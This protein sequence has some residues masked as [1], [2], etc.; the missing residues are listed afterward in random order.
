[1]SA[2]TSLIGFYAYAYPEAKMKERIDNA[3]AS[4]KEEGVEVNFI[5]YV[6]DRDEESIKKAKEKLEKTAY[7]STSITLVISA[8]VE[9]PPVIRVISDHFHMPMLMWSIAGYRIDA[10]LVSP[11]DAAG[12]T[13]LNFALKTFGIKH[14]SL[15]DIV[16][17]KSR[18]D[19]AAGF[20]KFADSLKNLRNTRIASF[21]YADMDL[22]PL[23]YDGTLIKKYTGIHVDNLDLIE[24]KI[25]MD[26]VTKDQ[27]SA[28]EKDLNNKVN[29]VHEPTKRDMEILARSYIAINKII[30]E[31]NYKAISLKCQFGMSKL[32]N[33]SPCM[34]ESLIGDKV[35]TICECDVP[36]L[37]AQVVVKE[38]TETKSVFQEFYEFYENRM[39][40]GACGFVPLSL[41]T[42]NKPLAQGHEWG[43]TGGI[44]NVSELKTGRVTLFKLYTINGQMHMH[45]V[46]G[47]AKTPEKWQ[48]DGWEGKGPKL[49]SLEVELDSSL[50]EFQE[51]IAGQHY[52]V[53]YGDISR[54]MKRYC[55][56]TGIRYNQHE[57]IDFDYK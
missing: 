14:V 40:I 49:P 18:A 8:W 34:L 24:L 1:M 57:Q 29:Y 35:D 51:Y 50:E 55:K 16:D 23:M 38:L 45:L 12:A 39:L 4:L 3:V 7:D 32:M 42:G 41:C 15:Y 52:I 11:G 33:F 22:Y 31:K 19:E 26:E 36:G 43:D 5:G 25:L 37:V 46:T 9:S 48:E 44:M 6:S 21:G 27:I 54:L 28:F 13:G 47:N 53:A 2:K 56:F 10:G 20:I 17:K 30:D